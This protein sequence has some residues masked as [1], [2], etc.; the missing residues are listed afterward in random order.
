MRTGYR[1]GYKARQ[2]HTRVGTLTVQVPQDRDGTFS[3]QLFAPRP[4]VLT[5]RQLHG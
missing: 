2:L 1:N 5:R 4:A 3:T